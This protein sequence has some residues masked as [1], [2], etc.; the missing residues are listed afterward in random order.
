MGDARHQQG[1]P[2]RRHALQEPGEA[3]LLQ[4]R[5]DRFGGHGVEDREHLRDVVLRA[6]TAGVGP[7]RSLRTSDA[8]LPDQPHGCAQREVG[9]VLPRG[10]NLLFRKSFRYR[11]MVETAKPFS[12]NQRLKLG[13]R[14]L[15]L[16]TRSPAT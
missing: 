1:Y 14:P 4:R 6:A 15:T 13:T 12:S 16:S 9:A 10:L 7:A 5:L 11:N 2:A 8:L 3:T